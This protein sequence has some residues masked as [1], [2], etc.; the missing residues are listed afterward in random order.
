MIRG[1]HFRLGIWLSPSLLST[2]ALWLHCCNWSVNSVSPKLPKS[3]TMYLDKQNECLTRPIS[4]AI[5]DAL[6]R[7]ICQIDTLA[8]K[9]T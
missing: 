7:H 8:E 6:L 3:M 5:V 4:P 1:E 2:S 9:I